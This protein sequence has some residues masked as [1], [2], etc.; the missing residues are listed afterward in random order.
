MFLI[1]RPVH[2]NFVEKLK[3]VV[4]NSEKLN[5][6]DGKVSHD[7]KFTCEIFFQ[8]DHE[9]EIVHRDG[10]IVDLWS[11]I[12]LHELFC[13]RVIRVQIFRGIRYN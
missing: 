1:F 12:E 9:R 4:E 5:C 8:I 2:K 6:S 10:N 11:H 13:T 3:I 7:L